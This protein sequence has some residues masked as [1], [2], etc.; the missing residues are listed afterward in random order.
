MTDINLI[1]LGMC[2]FTVIVVILVL[3]IQFAQS[4]LVAS[5]KV[6]LCINGES[7]NKLQLA[8]GS[9]L[10]YALAEQKIYLPSACGG[11]GT[12]GQ[13]RV[14]VN[15]G[16]GDILDTE[17]AKL[18]AKQV[19]EHY[20]LSC[21]LAVKRDMSIELPVELLTVKKWECTVRSNRNVATFIKELVLDLPLGENV[22]FRAGGYI[23]I[24]VPP[25]TLKYTEFDIEEQ[26]RAA[27]DQFKLWQYQSTVDEF[28]ERAYSMANFPQE[29]GIIMLNVRI[30]SPP[31]RH[32]D[33][34]PGKVSSYIFNLKPGD[35]VT[36]SG[37]FGEF[38]AKQTDN[39]MIFVGGGSG[40]APMRSHIFDQLKRLQSK[41][42]ISFWY[43]ARSLGEV[44]YNQDFNQ[45]AQDYENFA[46]TIGLSDPQ[47]ED[48]WHGATGFIHQILYDKYLKNHPTPEDCEYYLCGPPMMISAVEKML[49][50]L[51]VDAKNILF[52]KF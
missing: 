38:F 1:I 6:N 37:P 33:V 17:R 41:R 35:K 18:S 36:I 22:D 21:Q 16:G 5:G 13:C 32:A 9:K 44:F 47:P 24:E 30:S 23:L 3:I 29:Q 45:L 15:S 11:S 49:Y 19:H 4:R 34:P 10:L 20:R 52:D 42:K 31:P 40:M 25:H 14:I 46:W 39:E 7:E 50:D 12:C 27:W 28:T 8:V 2:L 51:G 43:G 48:N 26:F